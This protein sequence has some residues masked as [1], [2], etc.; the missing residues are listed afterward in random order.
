MVKKGAM[1][2]F[3]VYIRQGGNFY[4]TQRS[5]KGEGRRGGKEVGKD[6]KEKLGHGGIRVWVSLAKKIKRHRES[7]GGDC[8]K[9][10]VSKSPI[11][12]VFL[13]EEGSGVEIEGRKCPG[14]GGK[15]S[16]GSPSGVPFL[17]REGV[18]LFG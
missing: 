3:C 9:G 1:R 7:S 16:G 17:R 10:R 6:E 18:G 8:Q 14:L 2:A 11:F 13:S 15:A 4:E 12:L 5:E